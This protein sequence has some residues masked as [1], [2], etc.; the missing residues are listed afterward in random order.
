[1]VVENIE[2]IEEFEE[3]YDWDKEV[4]RGIVMRHDR[5]LKKW[6]EREA[7]VEKVVETHID[8]YELGMKMLVVDDRQFSQQKVPRA[9]DWMG[10]YLLQ[11]TDLKSCRALDDYT[12]FYD[13]KDMNRRKTASL[14][15]AVDFGASQDLH[16]KKSVFDIPCFDIRVESLKKRL[17]LDQMDRGQKKRL[18]KLG[19]KYKDR[20][21]HEL[22]EVM[23][24][25]YNTIKDGAWKESDINIV[26]LLILGYKEKEIAEELGETQQATHKKINRIVDRIGKWGEHELVA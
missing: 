12:F 8:E 22:Q 11:S 16:C 20:E 6:D 1:M 25:L 26:D 2:E 13:E 4:E 18:I 5:S 7:F 17:L 15:F 9:L 24:V 19:L 14:T 3:K 10:T 23:V 21:G